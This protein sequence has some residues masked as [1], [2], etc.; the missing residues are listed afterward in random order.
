MI[1]QKELKSFRQWI[2]FILFSCVFAKCFR[3]PILKL[4]L[5][6]F[7]TNFKVTFNRMF[8][9]LDI[10]KEIFHGNHYMEISVFDVIESKRNCES[11]GGK[12]SKRTLFTEMVLE[13]LNIDSIDTKSIITNFNFTVLCFFPIVALRSFIYYIKFVKPILS[14]FKFFYI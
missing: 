10:Y 6:Y 7:I 2:C 14:I 1:I 11:R 8:F 9:Y 13:C 5:Q 12:L 4:G 3:Y